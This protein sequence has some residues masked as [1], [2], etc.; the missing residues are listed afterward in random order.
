M[1]ITVTGKI[2][3]GKDSVCELLNQDKKYHIIDADKTAH[4]LLLNPDIIQEI[5]KVFFGGSFKARN[6]EWESENDPNLIDYR[7]KLARVVFPFRVQEL[8]AIIHPQLRKVIREQI[9]DNCLIN[10]ALLSELKLKEIS[11]LVVLVDSTF[12]NVKRRLSD[13]FYFKQLKKRWKSQKRI[14]WY[15][16][17]ADI[18]IPNNGSKN[19]LRF[20]TE[21]LNQKIAKSS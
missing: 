9:T 13:K 16:K 1:I 15:R 17:Q 8:N 6:R 7:K 19:D 14:Q 3:C 18:I 21:Y 5:N 10:A 11:N 2:G 4:S 12:Q 20:S